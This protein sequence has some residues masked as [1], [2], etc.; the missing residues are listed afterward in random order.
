MIQEAVEFYYANA[1]QFQECLVE[2][3]YVC[4]LCSV[5]CVLVGIPLGYIS[6]R[7]EAA[8][9]PIIGVINA[10]C[11]I[12]V[13]AMFMLMIPILGLGV[14]PAIIV[15]SMHSILTVV[16]NTMAGIQNVSKT[17]IESARGMGFSDRQICFHIEF[18]LAMPLILAGIR[19]AVVGVISSATLAAY[20]SAGG[21]GEIVISGISGMKYGAILLGGGT[22]VAIVLIADGFLAF[23]Q[24]MS[25]RYL[26]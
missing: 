24:S 25:S 11:T 16:V 21:L 9:T 5:I 3:I 2:H 22:I 23:L 4:L 6:A 1:A 7:H 15:I 19:T 10:L 17:V 13:I 20:V 12:P 14:V 8:A 18:P 26:R